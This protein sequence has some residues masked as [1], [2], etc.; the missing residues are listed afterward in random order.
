[1]AHINLSREA[2]A[3]LVA[4]AS[5]DF[6]AQLA[7]GRADELLSLLCLARPIERCPLLVAPAM[8]REM[9]AH[10]ATQRNVAQVRADGATCWARRGDQ[11][12]GEVGDGRM[13]EP[14]SCATS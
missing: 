3:M 6:I 2:D 10:P 7:Q 5:A 12:C 9:W 14:P 1:M 8:N 13:L 11:A 4:P